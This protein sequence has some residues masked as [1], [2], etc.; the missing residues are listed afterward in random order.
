MEDTTMKKTYIIPE[1]NVV[2]IATQQMLA[3]SPDGFSGGLDNTGSGGN[4]ALS[5]SMD[6]DMDW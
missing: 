5:P 6:D 1:M 3:A 4:N 2:I